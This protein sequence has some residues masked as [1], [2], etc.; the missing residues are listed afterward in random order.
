MITGS[1]AFGQ[2]PQKVELISSQVTK[3][4]TDKGLIRIIRPVFSHAGSTL[5]ADSANFDQKR[6]VFDAFG[7]VV[8]TQPSGT[9]VYSDLLNYNGNTKLA[10][11]TRNV[12]LIDGDATLTTSL[13]T[14]NMGSKIGTYLGGGKIV[15]GANVLTSKRG[16]YFANTRDAYFRNNVVLTTPDALIK[17]D[18]LRYNSTS[19]IA[20]FYGPTNIYGKDDTLYT[21]NGQYN[22][23]TDQARFGKKNLYTQGNKSLKGDS[24]FY[25][26]RAGIGRAMGNITF[27][28]AAENITFK[29]PLGP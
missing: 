4:F 26:R 24:L 29:G 18:T 10:I 6:N 11:L 23:V 19:K 25:D 8:I 3:G 16:Y 15:N 20:F 14:Y 9:T 2:T 28:D 21:E 17:S 5:A 12:R 27:I 22:T 1:F 7:N 13:L